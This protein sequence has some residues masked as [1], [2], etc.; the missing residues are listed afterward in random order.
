MSIIPSSLRAVC[1]SRASAG[2]SGTGRQSHEFGTEPPTI[3]APA[4]RRRQLGIV[5]GPSL[6]H[7]VAMAWS[8]GLLGGPARADPPPSPD[9]RSRLRAFGGVLASAWEF[10]EAPTAGGAGLAPR[11]TYVGPID[12]GFT[13]SAE[14]RGSGPSIYISIDEPESSLRQ[15]RFDVQIPVVF[16]IER[17]SS[18]TIDSARVRVTARLTG[19]YTAATDRVT[20]GM[21]RTDAARAIDLIEGNAE[22]SAPSL[23][24][25]VAGSTG[26]FSLTGARESFSTLKRACETRKL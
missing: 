13:M 23:V 1:G 19:G 10:R 8:A 20:I 16:R 11:V 6:I 18:R 25:E 21:A 24:V 3:D 5:I 7:V 4:A 12:R 15:L 14:C 2:A 22:T 26:T 17:K 9:P